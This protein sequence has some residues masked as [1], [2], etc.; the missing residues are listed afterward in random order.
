MQACQISGPALSSKDSDKAGT[1]AQKLRRFFV[2]TVVARILWHRRVIS[3]LLT[4]APASTPERPQAALWPERARLVAT[5][6]GQVHAAEHFVGLLIHMTPQQAF[7]KVCAA[8]VNA[9]RSNVGYDIGETKLR[10]ATNEVVRLVVPERRYIGL[11]KGGAAIGAA[12]QAAADGAEAQPDAEPL[13]AA[14]DEPMAQPAADDA[15]AAVDEHSQ[16]SDDEPAQPPGI[17]GGLESMA[18]D[19][20][21]VPAAAASAVIDGAAL[22]ACLE[23]DSLVDFYAAV[24]ALPPPRLDGLPSDFAARQHLD[25]LAAGGKSNSAAKQQY[26]HGLDVCATMSRGWALPSGAPPGEIPTAVVAAAIAR[27]GGDQ[28]GLD[29]VRRLLPHQHSPLVAIAS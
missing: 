29:T 6:N 11:K 7:Q 4:P 9:K 15:A 14:L 2:E 17:A 28:G 19:E 18:L 25:V 27:Q 23:A 8:L 26:S 21:T 3:P 24:T 22:D 13:D 10:S 16:A 5:V 20:A 12:Q 1:A